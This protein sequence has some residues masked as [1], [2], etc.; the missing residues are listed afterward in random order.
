MNP[1]P[2]NPLLHCVALF[3][4]RGDY[5]N[6]FLE[7]LAVAFPGIDTNQN[8]WTALTE[9]R[10]CVYGPLVWNPWRWH[11]LFDSLPPYIVGR[12]QPLP[13]DDTVDLEHR[14]WQVAETG[15]S[16]V[17]CLKSEHGV[18]VFTRLT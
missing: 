16:Q 13:P 9:P 14:K 5:M 15:A 11:L 1:I 12:Q 8:T 17:P 2:D 4:D 7:Q 3:P 18:Q 10:P 6:P